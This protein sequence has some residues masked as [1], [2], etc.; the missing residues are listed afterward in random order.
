MG[1]KSI[2]LREINQT[3]ED[4]YH[5]FSHFYDFLKTKGGKREKAST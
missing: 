4:S 5:A 1:Q 2:V 3:L